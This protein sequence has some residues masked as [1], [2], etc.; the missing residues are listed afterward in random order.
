MVKVKKKKGWDIPL[1]IDGASGAFVVPFTDPRLKWDFRLEQVKSINA[2]GQKF[3]LV[4]AGLGWILWRDE[5]D[6]PEELIFKVNYLGGL[7]P[8]YT[9]NFS[10]GSAMVV[11]QYYNFLRLGK[12]GYRE[13]MTNCLA[14]ARHLSK[15]LSDSGRFV[16]INEGQMLPVVAL[17]LADDVTNY[18][19]Y[20]LSNKLR[21]RGWVISAY[22][23][24]PNAEDIA[25]MRIVVKENL[26]RDMTDVLFQ[27][28]MNACDYLEKHGAPKKGKPKK[29]IREHR[30]C[31]RRTNPGL[32]ETNT[33]DKWPYTHR[34][35]RSFDTRGMAT[36]QCSR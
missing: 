29:G 34:H 18:T 11:A 17:R 36:A 4:Y 7:M 31:L 10:K 32:V 15:Q 8:T 6:F 9:L 21:E 20:D 1:H 14:N 28:I 2:S 5:S 26:S 16:M 30:I 23:M 27:D 24:P 12:E 19:V 13:I 33:G 22:T 35:N 3:G 25:I